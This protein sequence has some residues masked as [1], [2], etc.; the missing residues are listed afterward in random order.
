[1]NAYD[2]VEWLRSNKGGAK[3]IHKGYMYTIHKKRY[4]RIR[5]RCAQRTLHCKVSF[6]F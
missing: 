3:I 2:Q 1:M 4:G 5:W 6:F